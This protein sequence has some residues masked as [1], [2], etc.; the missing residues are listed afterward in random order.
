MAMLPVVLE[1]GDAVELGELLE[2]LHGRLDRDGDRVREDRTHGLTGDGERTGNGS[3]PLITTAFSE[4]EP[5]PVVV[6]PEQE[7]T[8]GGVS[9]VRLG[10]VLEQGVGVTEVALEGLTEPDRG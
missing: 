4:A 2:F 7:P 5:H 6:E 10:G 1:A 8:G 9:R 3:A